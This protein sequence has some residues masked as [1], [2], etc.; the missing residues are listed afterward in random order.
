MKKIFFVLSLIVLL[1]G[2]DAPYSL[3]KFRNVLNIAKLQAPE[4]HYNPLYSVKY[5]KFKNYQNRYFYLQD[6]KY[7]VFVM[8][9][10]KKRSELRFKHEWL[11]ETKSPKIIFARVKIFPLSQVKEFTFLQIHAD[12]NRRGVNGK[13]ID[14]PLLRITWWHEQHNLYNHL[15]AVIRLSGD[16]YEQKYTKIDLGPMPDGFFTVKVIVQNSRMKVYVNGVLK[17]NMNVSYW[18]GYWNYFKAGVY[19]Q[20]AGCDKA[21]FDI[22]EVKD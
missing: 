21:L 22:L 5:G 18:D 13:I 2:H 15:W 1:F 8:C 14:K 9:G 3:K 6:K 20:G 16:K 7:M 11:V 19:N 12:S 17:I 10:K 4:S